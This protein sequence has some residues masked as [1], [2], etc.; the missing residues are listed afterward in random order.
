MSKLLLAVLLG[1]SG[2]A[3]A[4]D[5]VGL[6]QVDD[7]DTLFG[8]SDMVFSDQSLVDVSDDRP[9][10]DQ[11][12]APVGLPGDVNGDQKQEVIVGR[13]TGVVLFAKGADGAWKEVSIWRPPAGDAGV[14]ALA[15]GD[16]DGDGKTEVF[17]G[18]GQGQNAANA[19]R[20]FILAW[21]ELL[22]ALNQVGEL[23]PYPNSGGVRCLNVADANGDGRPDLLVTQAYGNQHYVRLYAACGD[24]QWQEVWKDSIA[25]DDK[26]NHYPNG[27]AAADLDGD[28][29]PEIYVGVSLY[30]TDARACHGWLYVYEMTGRN[31]YEKIWESDD[32]GY[33][34]Q[35]VRLLREKETGKEVVVG[36]LNCNK[37]V[38]FE[39]S[40]EGSYDIA[41][42]KTEKDFEELFNSR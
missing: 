6:S 17:V 40:T 15:Q 35:D 19:C 29:K 12:G 5:P 34:V 16:T 30:D 18:T 1:F 4:T 14:V 33:Y 28:N 25:R 39:V 42:V 21:D 7:H 3:F 13:D 41:G 37:W 9:Q 2:V 23:G 26:Y 11:A 31:Q 8:S 36:Q 32:M 20:V 24:D 10:S 27:V 22:E 38:L